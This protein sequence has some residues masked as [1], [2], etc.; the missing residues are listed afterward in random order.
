ML[1]SMIIVQHYE[2]EIG[3][4]DSNNVIG[5]MWIFRVINLPQNW[6]GIDLLPFPV[7]GALTAPKLYG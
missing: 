2:T 7:G 4:H 5:K 6:I 1:G 3:V